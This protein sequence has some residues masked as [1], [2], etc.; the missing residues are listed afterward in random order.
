MA[1]LGDTKAVSLT[2]LDG[3]IGDFN[4]KTTNTYYLGTSSL[5]WKGT[6][7]TDLNATNIGSGTLSV[8]R[9]PTSGV[10]ANSYGNSSNQTP[11]F[12]DTFKVPYL[13]IDN[14]GRITAATQPTI[15]IPNTVFTGA[16]SSADGNIGLV[17]KPLIADIDS[18]LRGNCTWAT[19]STI[20]NT[21]SV[22]DSN[23]TGADYII[24][25]YAGGGTTTTTYH[26]KPVSKVVNATTVK[27]ALGT[28]SGGTG[29][30]KQDGTW[31]TPTDIDSHIDVTARGTTV[32]YLLADTTSPTSNHSATAVA[33]SDVYL[34]TTA[35]RLAATSFKLAESA[36]ITYNTTTNAID[37]NF[38]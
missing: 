13:T 7:I 30:L 24:A 15:K 31:A 33:E 32:A 25:Q 17:K 26:R 21:L 18:I 29:F 38:I 22:G 11:G 3:V 27:A 28:T 8:D 37:F 4:P 1:L 10:T 2:L 35:G 23:A 16:T 34:D 9:L 5:T 20:I 14:K 19:L 36:T 12:G 6:Y